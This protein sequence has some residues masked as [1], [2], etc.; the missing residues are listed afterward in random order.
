MAAA[1]DE[2]ITS[3]LRIDLSNLV[4]LIGTTLT[5]TVL[6]IIVSGCC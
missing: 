2:L 3:E 4:V 1:D 5:D 6:L